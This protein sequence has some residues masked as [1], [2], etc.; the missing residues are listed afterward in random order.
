[1]EVISVYNW[2]TH[3]QSSWLDLLVPRCSLIGG[4]QDHFYPK[5]VFTVRIRGCSHFVKLKCIRKKLGPGKSVHYRGCSHFRGVH[6][7][8]FHCII[9]FPKSADHAYM[10]S[11]S[12]EPTTTTCLIIRPTH[13][14][15]RHTFFRSNSPGRW[16]VLYMFMYKYVRVSFYWDCISS[17]VWYCLP[18]TACTYRWTWV[19]RT[20]VWRIFAYDGQYAWSQSD[21]YQVFVICIL[22]ILHMTEQFSW[23][24]WV[25]HIQVHLYYLN[26]VHPCS[27]L[28]IHIKK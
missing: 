5:K 16:R 8:R 20:T 6:I 3:T 28:F 18:Y 22:R 11:G 10:S 24:H 19:W 2:D 9:V 15:S 21:A 25:R 13:C 17:G 26:V 7:P 12:S 1:M 23:S 4:S 27:T 14:Y